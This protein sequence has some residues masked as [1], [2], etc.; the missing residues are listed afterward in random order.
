MPVNAVYDRTRHVIGYLEETNVQ[1]IAMDSKKKILGKYLK[2]S[3]KTFDGNNRLLGNGNM[4]M[5]FFAPC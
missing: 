2:S 3:D 5:R 1:V 4:T